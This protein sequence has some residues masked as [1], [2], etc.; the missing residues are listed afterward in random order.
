MVI[1]CNTYVAFLHCGKIRGEYGGFIINTKGVGIA[2]TTDGT[3]YHWC[4]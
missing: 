3:N 1:V 4:F 2:W